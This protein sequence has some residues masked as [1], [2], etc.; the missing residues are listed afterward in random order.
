[1]NA[2]YKFQRFPEI[3]FCFAGKTCDNVCCKR[4]GGIIFPDQLTF[5]TVF[6]RRISPVHPF[7]SSV[8]SALKRQM[9]MRAYFRKRR[10]AFHKFLCDDPGFQRSQPDSSDPF[11]I[12]DGTDQRQKIFFFLILKI[13]SVGAEM[14]S[15]KNHLLVSLCRKCFHLVDDLIR[16]AAAHPSSGIGNNAVCAELVASVLNFDIGSYVFRRMADR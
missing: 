10:N 14:D 16:P 1:M 12:V 4:G 8:A 6:L 15:C 3:F 13:H 5:F 2:S 9:K 11:Y 7:Q